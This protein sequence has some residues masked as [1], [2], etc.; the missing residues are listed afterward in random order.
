MWLSFVLTR[1]LGLAN[2]PHFFDAPEYLKL[3]SLHH[4]VQSLNQSHDPVHPFYL[5]LIQFFSQPWQ[6]SL[7]S[8]LFGTLGVY[9][10]YLV[11]KVVYNQT[12][13]RK[14]VLLLMFFPQLFLLQTNIVHEPIEQF[15]FLATLLFLVWFHRKKNWGY[16]L[17]SIITLYFSL[18]TF[19][20]ILLWVPAL[21]AANCLAA[22]AQK[23]KAAWFSI[24]SITIAALLAFTSYALILPGFKLNALIYTYLIGQAQGGWT[25]LGLLR[26]LRNGSLILW[27]G[28]TPLSFLI[29]I[30][31][32]FIIFQKKNW[33][34]LIVTL[35]FLLP[36]LLSAKPWYGGLYGRYSTLIGYLLA[37]L[38]AKYFSGKYYYALI[39]AI[40]PF[41]LLTFSLYLQI[42]LPRLQAK[43]IKS[44]PERPLYLV[45]SDYQRP[46]LEYEEIADLKLLI[47]SD[48][49]INNRHTEKQIDGLLK[50]DERVYFTRQALT[51]PYFQYDGQSFHIVSR[52]TQGKAKLAVYLKNKELQLVRQN[53]QYPALDIFSW[54]KNGARMIEDIK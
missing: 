27:H 46:Q 24:A 43:L 8:A 6:L 7:I 20:G 52:N 45:I 9:V 17:L 26:I 25:I 48:S 40:F 50:K 3:A 47:V 38:G 16:W 1:I 21:V 39:G 18:M 29:L 42:P 54:Q 28:F 15:F 36:F 23:L 53:F 35:G 13:G 2:Y 31:S 5:W 4:F 37:I 41:F 22:Q 49:D 32:L 33:G 14:T 10:F 34:F 44:L 51:F 19:I 11:I 30:Y 12:L